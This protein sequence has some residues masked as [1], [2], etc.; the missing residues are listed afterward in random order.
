MSSAERWLFIRLLQRE[1][2]LSALFGENAWRGS[3]SENFYRQN[4]FQRCSVDRGAHRDNRIIFQ[5]PSKNVTYD[6]SNMPFS[7]QGTLR[8]P[9]TL[10]AG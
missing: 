9:L 2:H 7:F 10:E 6:L 8:G 3:L 5:R 1:Y 4:T